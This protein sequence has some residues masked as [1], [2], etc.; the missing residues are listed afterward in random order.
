MRDLANDVDLYR[1]SIEF[2]WFHVGTGIKLNLWK[3]DI[4]NWSFDAGPEF[5][6]AAADGLYELNL[7]YPTRRISRTCWKQFDNAADGNSCPFAA[8]GAMDYVHFP[9]ADPAACDKGY[10]TANGCLAH[11]MKRYYGAILAEP[12]GVRI[13]TTRPARGFGRSPLTSVSLVAESSR[14]GGAGV[15]TD[16]AMPVNCKTAAGR[17]ESDYYEALGIVSEGPI[18]AFGV[19]HKL[20]GQYYHGS[21]GPLGL[22]TALGSDPAGAQDYFSLDESGNQTGGDWRKVYYGSSTYKDNFAAGT[23]FLV[24]R[25][26]DAKGLQLSKPAEHQME[27]IVQSGMKGWWDSRP[28][29]Y[30]PY[31]SSGSP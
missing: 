4:I 21:P 27:A 11:G 30:S 2:S 31:Q 19:N 17:D 5:K 26:F 24:M 20:D 6:I 7:P 25:R 16:S 15:Y 10:E 9:S 18:G 12:Q 13:R 3:G 29:V 1:A 28:C 23:A 14:P 22:R 8:Q